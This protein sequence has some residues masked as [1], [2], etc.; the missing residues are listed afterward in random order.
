MKELTHDSKHLYNILPVLKHATL[1]SLRRK[2]WVARR[3]APLWA[4]S[5]IDPLAMV[6]IG[7][8]MAATELAVLTACLTLGLAGDETYTVV[9]LT[10]GLE[11]FALVL[12]GLFLIARG[13]AHRAAGLLI[14]P[15]PLYK[16][17]WHKVHSVFWYIRVSGMDV[18]TPDYKALDFAGLDSLYP[19]AVAAGFDRR[20]VTLF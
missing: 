9:V 16:Q 7:L 15:T 5:A 2:G 8:A 18:F 10:L 17:E 14:H 4:G 12:A 11:V 13:E 1:E 6:K 3:S 20:V 19:Y